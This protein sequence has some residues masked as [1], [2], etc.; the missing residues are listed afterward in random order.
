MKIID[1]LFNIW[2]ALFR[3]SGKG[4]KIAAVIFLS[5]SLTYLILGFIIATSNVL[6]GI[7]IFN[8]IGPLPFSII[9]LAVFGLTYYSLNKV[10][11]K[12]QRDSGEIRYPILLSLMTPLLLL[13]P[14]FLF[15]Y[16][17]DK[18]G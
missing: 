12:G 8:Y 4:G 18:L 16:I 6:F 15:I 3:K 7:R 13:T 17:I 9:S 11:V 1:F 2:F 14:L 5:P 10:Y